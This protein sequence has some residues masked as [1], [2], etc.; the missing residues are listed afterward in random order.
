MN[1]GA[2]L[3]HWGWDDRW[4][5]VLTH[6]PLAADEQVGRVSSQERDRCIVQLQEGPLTA[7]LI[8][9]GHTHRSPVTGD[10]IRVRPGP[11][12]SDPLSIVGILQR[13]SAVS[14]GSAGSIQD[15]QVLASNVDVIWI[16]QA[17]DTSPNLR[18]IER[19]LAVVWESGA[20]PEIVLTKSDLANDLSDM[21]AEVQSIALGVPLHVVSV[22]DVTSVLRLRDGLRPGQTV[23]LLGPSGAGKSTLINMMADSPLAATAEVRT[24]DRKGRHTTTR[25][26]LFA[27]PGGALLMDSP[28]IRE[29]RLWAIDEGI[30]LA[31]PEIDAL[32]DSCRFRDCQHEA[33][34]GCAVLN[35]VATGEIAAERLESFR[36]LRAEA[37]YF[38]RK[39]NPRANAEAVAKHKTAL[40]TLKA[41][42][43]YKRGR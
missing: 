38:E 21:L 3:V 20:V 16:V 1:G 14:R 10:W 30:D 25:R 33:E 35:A 13:R 27:M 11:S 37:A 40:K 42:P 36:K 29:L 19:Y 8:A 17:L 12:P 41:H 24:Q 28:G 4:S 26:E 23:A 7:R 6:E 22:D 5:E 2:E 9:G 34:P 18:R 15:E 43:K 32:A 39:S 31:F